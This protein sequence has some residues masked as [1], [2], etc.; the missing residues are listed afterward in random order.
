MNDHIADARKMVPQGHSATVE[1]C[2]ICGS[3]QFRVY[4]TNADTITLRAHEDVPRG[5]ASLRV[6]VDGVWDETK[7]TV[8]YVEHLGHTSTVVYY[9]RTSPPPGYRWSERYRWAWYR[10]AWIALDRC[11]HGFWMEPGLAAQ[12]HENMLEAVP[13]FMWGPWAL[14]PAQTQATIFGRDGS[15][16]SDDPNARPRLEIDYEEPTE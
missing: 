10:N 9:S 12:M 3:R 11:A 14:E 15:V 4:K 7:V 13:G 8:H 2:L 16:I 5:P 1:A 6:C